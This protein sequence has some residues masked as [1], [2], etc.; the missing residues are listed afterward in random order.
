MTS[1]NIVEITGRFTTYLIPPKN[2]TYTIYFYHNDGGRVYFEN[3]MEINSWV[4]GVS[5]EYFTSSMNAGQLYKI[6]PEFFDNGYF[7]KAYKIS[8]YLYYKNFIY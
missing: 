5:T 2:D 4:D 7:A 8:I 6:V 1:T 3:T